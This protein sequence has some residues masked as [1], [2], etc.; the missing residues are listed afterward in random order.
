MYAVSM[1]I[2]AINCFEVGQASEYIATVV[3]AAS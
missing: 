2:L 1:L 3:E